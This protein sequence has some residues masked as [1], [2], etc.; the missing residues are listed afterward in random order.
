VFRGHLVHDLGHRSGQGLGFG[1]HHDRHP[2]WKFLA[3]KAGWYLWWTQKVHVDA[4]VS[5]GE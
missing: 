1:F 5:E 2:P 3:T 4:E